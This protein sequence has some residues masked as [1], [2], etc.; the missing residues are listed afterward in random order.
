[1]TKKH[2]KYPVMGSVTAEELRGLA[3]E[4]DIEKLYKKIDHLD[5]DIERLEDLLGSIIGQRQIMMKVL[6]KREAKKY[7]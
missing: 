2:I 7:G 3:E 1:M 5:T 4:W 6:K